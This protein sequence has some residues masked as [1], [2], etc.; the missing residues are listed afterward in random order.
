MEVVMRKFSDWLFGAFDNMSG[1]SLGIYRIVFSLFVYVWGLPGFADTIATYP[2]ELYK[3]KNSLARWFELPGMV[4]FQSLDFLI[5]V[6]LSMM[7]FGVFTRWTS[8]LFGLGLLVGNSFAYS[9][10]KVDHGLHLLMFAPIVMSFSNWGAFYSVDAKMTKTKPQV[11]TWPVAVLALIVAFAMFTAGM[12]KLIGGW[13]I[14]EYQAIRFH[15]F[16]SFLNGRSGL[17]TEW[18][19]SVHN[20][21]FWEALDYFIVVFEIGFLV[22][23]FKARWF[24]FWLV[25]ALLFH[26]GV[27]LVLDIAFYKNVAIYMLFMQWP[28]FTAASRFMDQTDRFMRLLPALLFALACGAAELFLGK[29]FLVEWVSIPKLEL[30]LMAVLAGF[31]VALVGEWR[32]QKLKSG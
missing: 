31:I 15:V 2:E 25:G 12:Q 1:Q 6:S 27:V 21:W 13:L 22:A 26:L 24:Y 14:P 29:V 17:L 19:L 8:L 4:F 10:G 32:Y 20:K 18:L 9:F 30:T 11:Q 16:K 7:L 28:F 23:V 3:P 5:V